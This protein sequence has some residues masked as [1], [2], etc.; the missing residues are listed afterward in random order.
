M[1]LMAAMRQQYSL[2]PKFLRPG[3][4]MVAVGLLKD[5]TILSDAICLTLCLNKLNITG[6]T[7]GTFKDVEKALE[8]SP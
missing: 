2:A 7:P 4:K 6:I 1:I 8:I 3:A 5:S